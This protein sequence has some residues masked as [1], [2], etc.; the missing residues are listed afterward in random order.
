MAIFASSHLGSSVAEMDKLEALDERG[1]AQER[2]E[3]LKDAIKT[4]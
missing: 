2:V 4:A 1:K 3:G